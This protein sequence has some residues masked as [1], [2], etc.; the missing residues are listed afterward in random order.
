MYSR[1]DRVHRAL[2]VALGG[3]TFVSI[4]LLFAWD[5]DPKLFTGPV[6]AWLEAFSLAGIAVAYLIY[7]SA[8]HPQPPEWLKA[9]MLAV[10]FLF[11]AANQIWPDPQQALLF[12]DLA[13][14][15]FVLDVF[16]VM[17]GWPKAPLD[18]SFAEAHTLE[19]G[20]ETPRDKRGTAP[21]HDAE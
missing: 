15:L 8:H 3:I 17:I 9:S 1:L 5:L 18:E 10:A 2:P 19:E 21:T 6:H 14:A 16:L 13:I 7:Q 20:H 11:W 12:N 4:A